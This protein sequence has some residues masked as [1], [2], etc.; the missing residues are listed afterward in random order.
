MNNAWKDPR[1]SNTQGNPYA[2]FL[3]RTMLYLQQSGFRKNYGFIR[4][5]SGEFAD[6]F[7]SESLL[8][9]NLEDAGGVFRE[10]LVAWRGDHWKLALGWTLFL[11]PELSEYGL[12]PV[13]NSAAVELSYFF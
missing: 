1:Y 13:L 3:Q 10:T 9:A 2:A 6:R 8:L 11:G 4:L 12:S 5:D 7:H